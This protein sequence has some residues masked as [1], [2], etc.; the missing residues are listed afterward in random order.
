MKPEDE[1]FQAFSTAFEMTSFFVIIANLMRAIS[2]LFS[3]AHY[4][5][6]SI[7]KSHW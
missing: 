3:L 1:A 5:L 6:D 7:I 2:I 4:L